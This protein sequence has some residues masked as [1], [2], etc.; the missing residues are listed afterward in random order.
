[1]YM[2]LGFEPY[3]HTKAEILEVM[4]QNHSEFAS[5]ET[6]KMYFND[7]NK[8]KSRLELLNKV[9]FGSKA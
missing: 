9:Y 4:N 3:S 1:M 6:V 7:L 5:D 8:I 2:R